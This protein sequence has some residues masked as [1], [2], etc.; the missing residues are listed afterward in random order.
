MEGKNKKGTAEDMNSFQKAWEVLFPYLLYYLAYSG[1]Y[2]M[3]AFLQ[4]VLLKSGNEVYRRFMTE[5]A[6]TI[7]GVMG[8]LSMMLGILPVLPMLKKELRLRGSMDEGS[9]DL[10]RKGLIKELFFTGIL[11]CT[12]IHQRLTGRWRTTSMAWLLRRDCFSMGWFLPWRKKWFSA[13]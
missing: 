8:G 10:D 13:V 11:A 4:E 6:S 12:S 9:M 5:Q 2:I 1:A 7:A 3:L